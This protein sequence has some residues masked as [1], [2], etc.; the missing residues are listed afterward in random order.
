MGSRLSIP[1]LEHVEPFRVYNLLQDARA[2]YVYL[3]AH[4]ERNERGEPTAIATATRALASSSAAEA[5]AAVAR[6]LVRFGFNS[7]AEAP[8]TLIISAAS[9]EAAEEMHAAVAHASGLRGGK[10]DAKRFPVAAAWT[11]DAARLARE[12]PWCV[13]APAPQRNP[14]PLPP[15]P[16]PEATTTRTTTRWRPRRRPPTIPSRLYPSCVDAIERRVFLSNWAQA[17]DRAV[18]VDAMH[19]THVVNCTPDH[20]CAHGCEPAAADAAAG[21]D[22]GVATAAAAAVA[23]RRDGDGAEVTYL[24]VPV[25]DDRGRSPPPPRGGRLCACRRYAR[26]ATPACSCTVATASR[27]PPRSSPRGD[28]QSPPTRSRPPHSPMWPRTRQFRRQRA[29]AS[30]R[31]AVTDPPRAAGVSRRDC[32]VAALPAARG[33]E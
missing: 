28:S 11:V 5:T 6:A 19:I 18:V 22:N 26:G 21:D 1:A 20:A 4:G 15:Q 30:T 24:R 31:A 25:V 32:V 10:W 7:K 8:F 29:L 12:F 3:N 17:G 9:T 27:D 33:A 14:P 23:A 16:V 13:A 2:C